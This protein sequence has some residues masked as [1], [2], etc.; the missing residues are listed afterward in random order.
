MAGEVVTMDNGCAVWITHPF[1]WH[2]SLSVP[3]SEWVMADGLE[4]AA[5]RINEYQAARASVEAL[6]SWDLPEEHEP[7]V[8]LNP[9]YDGAFPVFIFKIESNG[10]TFL[11]SRDQEYI[12]WIAETEAH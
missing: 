3:V 12:Q 10:T 7:M 5:E 11:V 4:N 1:E 6:P 9:R 8:F 2:L